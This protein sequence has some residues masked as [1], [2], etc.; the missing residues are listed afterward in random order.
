MSW[1]FAAKHEHQRFLELCPQ[2]EKYVVDGG[3]KLIKIWLEVG[4]A[5]QERRFRGPDQDPLRQWKLSPMDV[6]SYTRWYDYSK[7]RDMMLEATDT[8]HAPWHIV[9]SDDKT[10]CP[11]QLHLAYP[12]GDSYERCASRR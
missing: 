8:K 4:Q 9:H 1:D 7:A 2:V 10:P 11:P 3:I 12:E 6:G 5:E